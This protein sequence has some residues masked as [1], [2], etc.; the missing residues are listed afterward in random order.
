MSCLPANYAERQLAADRSNNDALRLLKRAIAREMFKHLT[1]PCP[2]DDYSDLR[3]ARQ[4][5][6]ITLTTA[7]THFDIWPNDISR[8]ERGR[9]R[10]DTLTA[11]TANG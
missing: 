10:D 5:R 9:K 11:T 4:T 6:N 3:P 8:L 1:N 7:A 2:I